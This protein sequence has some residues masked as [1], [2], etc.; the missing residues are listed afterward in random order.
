MVVP[1]EDYVRARFDDAALRLAP[2]REPHAPGYLSAQQVVM[3][4]EDPRQPGLRLRED[5]LHA[6]YFASGKMSLHGDIAQSSRERAPGHA[7]RGQR[8]GDDRAP[9]NGECR[10]EIS[11]EIAAVFRVQAVLAERDKRPPPPLHIVVAGND[12]DGG[13]LTTQ[14]GERTAALKLAVARPLR[15]IA[16]D[17]DRVGAQIRQ[18]P[19]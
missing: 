8:R 16:A 11:P 6:L 12:E 7:M 13:G 2:A 18:H 19:L 10:R 14:I 3:D 1:T 15:E 17:H 4:H 9:G 5:R